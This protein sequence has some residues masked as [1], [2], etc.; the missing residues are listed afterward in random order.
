M[1]VYQGD[2]I[3]ALNDGNVKRRRKKRMAGFGCLGESSGTSFGIFVAHLMGHGFDDIT[4][5]SHQLNNQ[6]GLTFIQ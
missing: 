2:M 5:Y 6:T 1:C 3:D 4:R